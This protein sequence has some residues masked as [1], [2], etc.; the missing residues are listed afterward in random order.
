MNARTPRSPLDP[1][2][3]GPGPGA[4]AVAAG[5]ALLSGLLLGMPAAADVIDFDIEICPDPTNCSMEHDRPLII[6]DEGLDGNFQGGQ[7]APNEVAWGVTPLITLPDPALDPDTD[8]PREDIWWVW[9]TVRNDSDQKWNDFHITLLIDGATSPEADGISFGQ[10]LP[11]P[12]QHVGIDPDWDPFGF[13]PENGGDWTGIVGL[14][15]DQVWFEGP[16]PPVRPG[17]MIHFMFPISL[18]A[19]AP[20]VFQLEQHATHIPEPASLALLG[21]GLAGLG[22]A[23]RARVG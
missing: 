22:F 8:E 11:D 7:P 1:R 23:R 13:A 20:R 19:G 12:N 9:K 3:S 6:I 2:G 18:A 10:L 15:P 16:R 5:A 21:L 17:E 4:R 14:D